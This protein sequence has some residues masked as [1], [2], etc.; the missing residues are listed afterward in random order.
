MGDGSEGVE[1]LCS[2]CGHQEQA[3]LSYRCLDCALD[4]PPCAWYAVEKQ[5]DDEEVGGGLAIRVVEEPGD[6]MRCGRPTLVQYQQVAV[7]SLHTGECM[8]RF[9][10]ERRVRERRQR[11]RRDREISRRK[12]D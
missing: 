5:R 3:H 9:D 8:R 12:G 11:W 2:D 10:V 6:C 4:A 1:A 7:C